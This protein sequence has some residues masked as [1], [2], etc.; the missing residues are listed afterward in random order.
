MYKSLPFVFLMMAGA[1]AVSAASVY[2]FSVKSIDQTPTTLGEYKGKVLLVVNTASLCGY[3]PQYA[4]LEALYRKYKDQGLVIV[5]FPANNFAKQEPGTN[6]EIKTFCKRKYD[7]TFPMMA[8]ISVGGSDIDPLY[9]YLTEGPVPTGGPIK[10]NFTKFLVGKDGTVLAR[11]E[12]AVTP[13][14][15][16][17]VSAVEKALQ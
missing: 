9:Q 5:G 3:T 13:S 11:F 15:P 1:G 8:K 4:G 6:A 2:D 14:D 17:L 16:A 7:V 12:P 10:W